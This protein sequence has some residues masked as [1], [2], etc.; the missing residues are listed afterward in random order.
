M[1]SGLRHVS[2]ASG[3]TEPT[4]SESGSESESESESSEPECDLEEHIIYRHPSYFDRIEQ[5]RTVAIGVDPGPKLCGFQVIGEFIGPGGMKQEVLGIVVFG[6]N[7]DDGTPLERVAQFANLP[8]GDW[9]PLMMP[10][11]RSRVHVMIEKQEQRRGKNFREDN[12]VLVGVLAAGARLHHVE[13]LRIVSA[14]VK[15]GKPMLTYCG[16]P[17]AVVPRGAANR[18]KRKKLA[19]EVYQAYLQKTRGFEASVNLERTPQ[20]KGLFDACDAG[21]TAVTYFKNR[22]G[23]TK[24]P[25]AGKRKRKR[26]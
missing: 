16:L 11:R 25:T 9:L 14:T 5:A 4:L 15:L 19:V 22:D 18:L 26:E 2:G 21:L 23:Q 12:T 8:W 7:N 17:N 13:N 20:S 1:K 6:A 10:P 24:A 3:A